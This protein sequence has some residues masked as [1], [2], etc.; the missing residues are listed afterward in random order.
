[1]GIFLI[2]RFPVFVDALAFKFFC[3][4]EFYFNFKNKKFSNHMN[5]FICI[6]LFCDSFHRVLR[7][8][9]N[10]IKKKKKIHRNLL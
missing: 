5:A 1:M 6:F 9:I 10:K 3:T 8:F 2:Y 4:L 7:S